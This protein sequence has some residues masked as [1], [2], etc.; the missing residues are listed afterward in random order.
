M[1]NGGVSKNKAVVK[2]F[3]ELVDCKIIVDKNSHLM[4][5]FGIAIM[6]REC[7]EENVFNCRSICNFS[8]GNANDWMG[9]RS[10]HYADFYSV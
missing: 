5:A 6:A 8:G 1:F 7:K 3:E 2:A 9:M 4:G 10:Y